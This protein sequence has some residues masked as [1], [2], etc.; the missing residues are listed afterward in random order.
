M[1]IQ[2]ILYII[3]FCT[4]LIRDRKIVHLT[5]VYMSSVLRESILSLVVHFLLVTESI[6]VCHHSLIGPG[7]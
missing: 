3:P 7:R 2:M 4:A 5:K 6:V 1:I